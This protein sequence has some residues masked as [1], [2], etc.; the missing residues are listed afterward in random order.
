MISGTIKLLTRHE[1][2]WKTMLYSGRKHRT[3]IIEQWEKKHA[4]IFYDGSI[5]ITPYHNVS[6]VNEVTGQNIKRKLSDEFNKNC[7]IQ[8]P[9]T[10]YDN[11]RSL[12]GIDELP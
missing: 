3:K 4:D 7:G 10:K 8:R 11:N 1:I 12:Y 9:E 5:Q 6:M 2:V